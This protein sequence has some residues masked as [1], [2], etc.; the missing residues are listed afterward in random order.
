M[1]AR[2]S[3]YPLCGSNIIAIVADCHRIFFWGGGGMGKAYMS[4]FFPFLNMEKAYMSI[5]HCQ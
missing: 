3:W 1:P 4:I 5:K 2:D